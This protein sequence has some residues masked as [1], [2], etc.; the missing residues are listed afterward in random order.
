MLHNCNYTVGKICPLEIT[1]NI[2]PHKWYSYIKSKTDKPDLAAISIFSEIL[3]WYKPSRGGGRKFEADF[4]RTSYDYFE[5]K[6]GF[7]YQ[8]SRRALVRLE[9]LGLIKRHIRNFESNGYK[10]YN[11]LFIELLSLEPQPD[12]NSEAKDNKKTSSSML[13]FDTPSLQHC[14]DHIETEISTENTKN[15]SRSDFNESILKKSDLKVYLTG[16]SKNLFAI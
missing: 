4:W 14:R 8:K 1:G 6:F 12:V 3:Y 15:K 10:Y 11:H 13:K 9:E 7:N 16:T 2:I 5:G